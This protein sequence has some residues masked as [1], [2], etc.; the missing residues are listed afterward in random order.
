[1]PSAPLGRFR[2]TNQLVLPSIMYL[3]YSGLQNDC[4]FCPLTI[5]D[6]IRRYYSTPTL[7]LYAPLRKDAQALLR[8]ADTLFFSHGRI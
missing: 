4:S 5:R 7:D 6:V 3:A 2:G 8:H 1:M